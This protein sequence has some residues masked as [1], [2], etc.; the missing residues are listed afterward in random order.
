MFSWVIIGS[1]SQILRSKMS[2]RN[3]LLSKKL[4][5]RLFWWANL[6]CCI[7]LYLCLYFLAHCCIVDGH[8]TH[9]ID[10]NLSL[11]VTLLPTLSG[12]FHY[13]YLTAFLNIDNYITE[14][15]SSFCLLV[16]IIS[17]LLRHVFVI[18]MNYKTYIIQTLLDLQKVHVQNICILTKLELGA[19]TNY[20]VL[21]HL[22]VIG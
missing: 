16:Y 5:L 11:S 12:I 21:W 6:L 14:L 1:L 7:K 4:N 15:M 17:V 13:I 8:F 22:V 20:V 3:L 19:L 2:L 9:L 10:Y 18:T